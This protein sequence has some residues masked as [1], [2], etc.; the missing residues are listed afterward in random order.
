M[1]SLNRS[2]DTTPLGGTN[3]PE[4]TVTIVDPQHPF[5]G[6]TFPLI[7][8]TDTQTTGRSCVIRLQEGIER[9]VPLDATDRGLAPLSAFPIPL[10]PS[11]LQQLL[12]TF[13]RIVGQQAEEMQDARCSRGEQERSTTGTLVGVASDRRAPHSA[14]T[15]MEVA[16]PH[17]AAKGLSS[18]GSSVPPVG[19]QRPSG[20]AR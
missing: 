3:P 20:G 9:S 11:S 18:P 15:D 16:N 13:E 5:F 10:N 17:P 12:A 2:F 14:G 4:E 1:K 6:Q 19:D 8:I 7:A